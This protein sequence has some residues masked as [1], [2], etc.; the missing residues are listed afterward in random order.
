MPLLRKETIGYGIAAILAIL[1]NTLLVFFKEENP[2]LR[3]AMKQLL[4][5]HWIAHGVFVMLAFVLL[6]FLLSRVVVPSR[7]RWLA[8]ALFS[9]AAFGGLG[10]AALFLFVL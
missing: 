3:A 2:A 4:Y 7:G 6:G 1:G 5:H 8:P 10:L 9:A